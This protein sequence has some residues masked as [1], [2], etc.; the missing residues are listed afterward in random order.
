[1]WVLA[2]IGGVFLIERRMWGQI[3]DFVLQ[4]QEKSTRFKPG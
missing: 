2:E 1:V 3:L 4:G